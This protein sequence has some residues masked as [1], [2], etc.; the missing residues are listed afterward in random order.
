[1]AFAAPS[2]APAAWLLAVANLSA[3][4]A[5]DALLDVSGCSPG[6]WI[7]ERLDAAGRWR[8]AG[9]PADGILA[10]PAARHAVAAYRLRRAQ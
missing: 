1:L 8:R 9:A 3:D 10:A 4:D 6:P 7:A 2:G 5:P